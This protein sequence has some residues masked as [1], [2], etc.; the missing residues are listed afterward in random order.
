MQLFLFGYGFS[1]RA[2]ARRMAAKGW[3][4]TATF[5]DAAGA[6][7]IA[8]DGHRG[9]SLDDRQAVT[10][11]LATTQALLITAPPGPQGC[12]GLN[13]LVG[14]LA[15]A[16]AFP[17]WTGYLSTTGVYGDRRGGWV[18]ERSRLAAQSVEAAR[19]VGAE[20]DWWEVGRGMGLTVCTFRLPGI[21][22][23]G[24]SA[25]DRLREGRARRI[26]AEG[27]VFSRIHVDDLAAGLEASI[28]RPRAGAAYN[29]CDDEPAP[30][31][32][33]L[34][35]AA[36]LLGI[37]PPP[38]IALADAELSPAA[39]RFY[40]ESKRVSNALAKAELGWRPMYPTY[41]EG[42]AA[43]LAPPLGRN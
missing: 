37:E 22:G 25:F 16:G 29:L 19:R 20:R 9:V 36:G 26:V 10:D 18:T 43:I 14:P 40:A 7:R 8:A 33:V 21:Y 34:A 13:S 11:A 35:Y 1:G 12:P 32:E 5:R 24:R 6:A 23:P 41:R 31:S 17:D 27:Q 2:L 15:E 4:V 3:A 38:A 39:M 28:A 42:L 30:N